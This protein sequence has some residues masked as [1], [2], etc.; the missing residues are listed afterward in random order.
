M[1][2]PRPLGSTC[3]RTPWGVVTILR[4]RIKYPGA[5]AE[6]RAVF[7]GRHRLRVI[8]DETSRL[9]VAHA[10]KFVVKVDRSGNQALGE[11]RIYRALLPQDRR[12]FAA[13]LYAG[14]W[15]TIQRYVNFTRADTAKHH[16]ICEKVE[17]VCK[18]YRL[19]DISGYSTRQWGITNQGQPIIHDYGFSDLADNLQGV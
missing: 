13:T 8:S 5:S 19:W 2:T 16:A 3:E 14:A 18:R 10:K 6:I 7:L 17:E 15:F 11:A 12:Y 1:S 4:N 9:V